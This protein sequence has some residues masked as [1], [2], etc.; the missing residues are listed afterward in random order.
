MFWAILGFFFLAVLTH[1]S[2]FLLGGRHRFEAGRKLGFAQGQK[3]GFKR[4]LWLGDSDREKR[5]RNVSQELATWRAWK[6]RQADAVSE[7]L[8]IWPE[9]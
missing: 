5:E 8:A 7:E 6:R 4:G 3:E 2:C 1:L 9:D